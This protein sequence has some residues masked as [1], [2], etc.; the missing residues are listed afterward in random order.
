MENTDKIEIIDEIAKLYN[1]LDEFSNLVVK[2]FTKWSDKQTEMYLKLVKLDETIKEALSP[3]GKF[4]KIRR[5]DK[6]IEEPGRY[7]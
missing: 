4:G 2:L 1:Q 5:T 6:G 7:Y 3:T